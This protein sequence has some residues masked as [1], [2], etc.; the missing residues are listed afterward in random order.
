M[1][2][3]KGQ[4]GQEAQ[5]MVGKSADALRGLLRSLPAGTYPQLLE[6]ADHCLNIMEA[7]TELLKRQVAEEHRII[8]AIHA[9]LARCQRCAAEPT[10][11]EGQLR[12]TRECRHLNKLA[13]DSKRRISKH[14]ATA[15]DQKSDQARDKAMAIFRTLGLVDENGKAKNADVP[16]SQGTTER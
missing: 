11:P 8:D 13:M 9:H 4:E 5:V 7:H 1:D 15:S 3:R 14:R 10:G 6:E 16:G 12:N 2:S